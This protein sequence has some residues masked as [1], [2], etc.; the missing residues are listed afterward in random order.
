MGRT[1]HR[2]QGDRLFVCLSSVCVGERGGSLVQG[3]EGSP[4][5]R[6]EGVTAS[7]LGSVLQDGAAQCSP[8][9]PGRQCPLVAG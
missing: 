6:L 5:K 2:A 7:F 3:K 1:R 9:L 8:A 4:S